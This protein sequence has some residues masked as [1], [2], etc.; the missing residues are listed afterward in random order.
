[1]SPS[2]L[3]GPALRVV[4]VGL[5]LF[6]ES[7]RAQ[8]A[9]VAEVDWRP[10]AG[11]DEHLVRLLVATAAV[12]ELIAEANRET[13]DRLFKARPMWVDVRRAGDVIP[14]FPEHT[15]LHSGPPIGWERMC[16]P[17]RRAAAWVA[18]LE[19][20]AP[21]HEAA[22]RALAAGTIGLEPAIAHSTVC[23]MAGVLS[24]SMAVHVVTD[25]E[26]GITAYSPINEGRGRTTWTGNPDPSAIERL[27]WFRDEL[28]GTLSAGLR[29]G[30]GIDLFALF[31]QS[32]QMG[33]EMH[34][35]LPATTALLLRALA[36]PVLEA[37]VPG[38]VAARAFRFMESNSLFG[39]TTVMAACRVAADVAHGVQWSSV[40]T[41]M[42]RNGV[43]FGLRV[44]GLGD[45][46]VL[47]PAP[48][49]DEA[50]YFTGHD[51][52]DAAGDIGDSAI[53]EVVGLGGMAIAAAPTTAAFVGGSVADQ[54][55]ATDELREVTLASHPMFTL[56]QLG[57]AGTPVGIDVR[58]VV[59]TGIVPFIDTGAI[60]ERDPDVGQIGAGIAR[61]PIQVFRSA[62]VEL[63]AAWAR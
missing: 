53:L 56:P 23:P 33:D 30:E 29:E 7:V 22:A 20:W 48:P 4:N 21:D 49:L 51:V 27:A 26:T 36:G 45:R 10:P 2:T 60:H 47:A 40:V 31:S 17:H 18:V 5:D 58:R 34:A 63:G 25:R 55:L 44:G 24:P 14:D 9:P 35:R 19:G 32:I 41:G 43:D 28:A 59:E 52:T 50:I 1:M 61:A 6:A 57:F 54:L 15:L 11:G 8:D 38:P 16:G 46:W 37:G 62:L 39:L 42:S 13:M 12:R 3:F